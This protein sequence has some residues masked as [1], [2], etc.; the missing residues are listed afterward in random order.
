MDLSRFSS[1]QFERGVPRW[2]EA[3]WV[4]VKCLFFLPPLPFPSA[5]RAMLLRLFGARIGKGFVIRS[6]VHIW[7]P[8]R[9]IVGDHVWIGE[10]AFLLNLAPITIESHCCVSQRAFLC[11]GTHNHRL[12]TFDLIAKPIILRTGSW[13][14]AQSFVG[15]G[16]EIGEQTVVSAGSV[17]LRSLPPHSIAR[18]NPAQVTGPC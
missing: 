11:T 14:A 7:M 10:E 18:G 8:W 12:P 2:K 6:Q 15:P 9:L 5:F 17:V 16:V 13:I 3:L 1:E 4:L